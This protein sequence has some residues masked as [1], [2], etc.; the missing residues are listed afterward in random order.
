[1][2]KEIMTT[3]TVHERDLPALF[4]EAD[5]A[6]DRAQ[7]TYLRLSRINLVALVGAALLFA[8]PVADTVSAT[9]V[10]G[11]ATLLLGGSALLSAMAARRNDRRT[12]YE[13]RAVAESVKSLAWKYMC[14]TEP[15]HLADGTV[16]AAF[17]G[18]LRG[19]LAH[20]RGTPAL[21]GAPADPGSEITETMRRLRDAPPEWRL[22]VYLADRIDS[23]RVWYGRRAHE[24][25]VAG[26]RLTAWA[27]TFQALALAAAVM[28]LVFPAV[29]WNAVGAL[30]AAAAAFIAWNELKHHGELSNA[31]T[32]ACRELSVIASG[33]E[34]I[35]LEEDLGRFVTDA[36]TAISREHTLWIARRSSGGEGPD[37]LPSVL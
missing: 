20:A 31:Y 7:R 16:D 21:M 24:H 17:A 29:A 1:M 37:Q 30:S 11:A 14:R 6:S 25:E 5:G 27:L 34:G 19:V 2:T 9:L 15:F 28:L 23:Q 12:W 32:V 22:R 36:E 26:A 4:R 10:R 8:V 3:E 13:A 18:S 33:A 35:R